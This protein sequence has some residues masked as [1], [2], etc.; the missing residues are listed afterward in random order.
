MHSGVVGCQDMLYELHDLI[1]N[2]YPMELLLVL[3]RGYTSLSEFEEAKADNQM[4]TG[5][6]AEAQWEWEFPLSQGDLEVVRSWRPAYVLA[7][8]R[9]LATLQVPV[10]F[11]DSVNLCS[12]VTVLLED[13]S[14]STIMTLA[15]LD[16]RALSKVS[17]SQVWHQILMNAQALVDKPATATHIL[18]SIGLVPVGAAKV[19]QEDIVDTDAADA[20]ERSTNIESLYAHIPSDLEAPGD[21]EKIQQDEFVA[22][23][24]LFSQFQCYNAFNLMRAAVEIQRSLIHK[25]ERDTK[26]F[27]HR[28]S[29]TVN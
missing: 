11:S 1:A 19:E 15:T 13:K 7:A 17:F 9:G 27:K 2:A 4:Q 3:R 28:S 6:A 16:E 12:A 5:L 8:L 14:P 10:R 26:S 23:Q 25:A 20:P 22:Q 24:N 21:G 18:V 29:T